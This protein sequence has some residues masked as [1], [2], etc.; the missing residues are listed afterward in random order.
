[1]SLDD[2]YDNDRK[3]YYDALKTVNPK[4]CD[5]TAWLEYFSEG[6]A[7]SV[8]AIRKR[9]I[10]L[11]K[12]IKILRQKG[13]IALTERQ[14]KIVERIVSN[15]SISNREIREMFNLSNRGALD[16]I[17]KLIHLEVIRKKGE[18]RSIIYVLY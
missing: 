10:G 4:T 7:I 1:L 14:M 2:Y 17:E 8:E 9:V 6:V 11:S 3:A 12:D 18:G 5:T 15:G 16:E 13:Q